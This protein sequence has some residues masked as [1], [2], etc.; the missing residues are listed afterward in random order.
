[1]KRKRKIIDKPLQVPVISKM[2]ILFVIVFAVPA[3]ILG[4]HFTVNSEMIH[5][6]TTGLNGAIQTEQNIVK[7][8]VAYS[9]NAGSSG[10]AIM[11]AY[12]KILA[13]HHGATQVMNNHVDLLQGLSDKNEKLAYIFAGWFVVMILF[14]F[15]SL[16]KITHRIAGPLFLISE[17]IKE[18]KKN[19]RPEMRPL[20]K[21]DMCQNLY[22]EFV[23]MVEIIDI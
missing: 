23:D 15:F 12:G 11:P 13:D 7:A 19:R 17:A 2:T 18:I 16:L 1:M 20:R 21:G 8:F 3:F 6:T 10:S 5:V 4:Y 22:H 14:L 9:R